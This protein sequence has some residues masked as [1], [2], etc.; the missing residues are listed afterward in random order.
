MLI[1]SF[2]KRMLPMVAGRMRNYATMAVFMSYSTVYGR[3]LRVVQD[4]TES[5]GKGDILL[6]CTLRNEAFRIPHF[7]EHYR[8]LGV[9]HFVFVDNGSE[10]DFQRIV[11]GDEDV[12]VWYT[13][14][15]YKKSSFGMHWLNHLLRKY[16]SNHWCVVCDPDEFMVFPYS[17]QR[18]LYELTGFLDGEHKRSFFC[19]LLDLYSDVPVEDARYPADRDPVEVCSY[20]DSRGYVQAVNKKY[21]NVWVQGGPRRRLFFRNNPC[22]APAVNKMPLVKWKWY[23]SYISSTHAMVPRVLNIPHLSDYLA[24]TGCLLHFKFF[25]VLQEKAAEEQ[26]RKEHF[27]DSLEY[28]Q[29]NKH[30]SGKTL[31][32][33]YEG[34]VK[35]EGWRQLVQLGLMNI[36]K[37]F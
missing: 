28:R 5:I 24:P 23:Y 32:L 35:Y 26:V 1:P 13:E 4:N 22:S 29:Y 37:W 10:D 9:Q 7:L 34:S 27:S 12:S 15:S 18:N 17:D 25:S 19:L 3:E 6:F 16:G 14:K 21:F 33:I 36:G 31:P 11:Q 8:E 20:F 2:G 30:M